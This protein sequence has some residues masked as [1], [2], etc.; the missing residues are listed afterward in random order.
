MM[1]DLAGGPAN[2]PAGRPP[3]PRKNEVMAGGKWNHMM[4]QTHIG[5]TF[6]N[7]PSRNAMPA[8][9]EVLVAGRRRW[10]SRSEEAGPALPASRR[11]RR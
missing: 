4:D 5:Y 1:N 7:Q 3:V 11:C 10:A 8:V 9:Q 6:W 2:V